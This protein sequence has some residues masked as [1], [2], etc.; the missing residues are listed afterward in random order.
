MK[1]SLRLVLF[2]LTA[3]N[4]FQVSA[5]QATDSSLFNQSV[6]DIHQFYFKEIGDNAQIYQ[7]NEYIRSGL[8]A[9]GF[10]YYLAD[11]MFLG[12]ITYL[13]TLYPEKK[14]FYDLVKDQLIIYNYTHD[15]LIRLYSEKVDSF[16]VGNH[17]FIYLRATKLNGLTR[18]GFYEKLYAGY[19]SLVVKREKVFRTATGSEDQKYLQKDDY[20]IEK[21]NVYFPVDSK[22]RQL[23]V[24]EDQR[25]ALTKFIRSNKLNYKKD[26]ENALL[27]STIYYS[28]I[29]N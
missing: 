23:D 13:G 16:S 15:A 5:Q 25:V 4:F 19:P 6:S 21:N 1:L 7:G 14:F 28:R 17:N 20:Y 27:L 11:S 8:K 3:L 12:T 24:L 2:I 10:P 9:T 29:K 26:L 18:D 22:N